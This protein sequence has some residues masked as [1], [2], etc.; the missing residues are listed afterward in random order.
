MVQWQERPSVSITI[1]FRVALLPNFQ[2]E[3]VLP[4][5]KAGTQRTHIQNLLLLIALPVLARQPA[6][7]TKAF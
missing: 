1:N 2:A 6:F 4:I 7:R 3:S 5:A